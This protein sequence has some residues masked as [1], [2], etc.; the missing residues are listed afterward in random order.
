MDSATPFRVLILEDRASDTERIVRLLGESGFHF[1]CRTAKNSEEFRSELALNPDII[2]SDFGLF[3]FDALQAL[4]ILREQEL[5]IPLIVVT[6]SISEEVAVECIKQGASDYLWKDRL[7]RLPA[8]VKNALEERSLRQ[9][10]RLAEDRLLD[11]EQRLRLALEAAQLGIWE[12]DPRTGKIGFTRE[13]GPLFGMP[14]GEFFK[15]IDSF[16]DAVHPHDRSLVA[17]L[18]TR[19]TEPESTYTVDF[20]VSW[21]DA[22]EHWLSARGCVECDE[23]GQMFAVVMDLTE[24]VRREQ[25]AKQ[26]L[27]DSAHADRLAT[28]GELVSELAHELNQPLYAISNFSEACLNVS[29]KTEFKGA[30][31]LRDWLAQITAQSHRAGDIIRRVSGFVRKSPSHATAVH[32]NQLARECAQ[33]MQ[34]NL[35][36]TGIP[37]TLDLGENLPSVLADPVQ[38]QQVLVNLVSNAIDAMRSQTTEHREVTIQTRQTTS[39]EV[40]VSVQDCGPGATDEAFAHLFD[41]FFTTKSVGM[42]MGLAI[43]RSIAD[44]HGGHLEA[45]RNPDRGLTFRL[46][47]PTTERT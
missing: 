12:W 20:R 25:E 21:P 22:S 4:R 36:A 24:R 6:G 43:S 41:A 31:N 37:L 9:A 26:R 35:R 44:A 29:R 13:L 32:V 7:A 2:L 38:I 16:L 42:G 1:D 27:A 17:R 30:D 23:S 14:S 40:T 3:Q 34:V 5:D 28:M 19:K 33:L 11:S 46:V 45:H 18:M 47:L 8:A 39:E 10:K 15:C